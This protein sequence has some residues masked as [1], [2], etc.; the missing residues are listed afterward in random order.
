MVGTGAVATVRT[1][2]R[3]GPVAHATVN[4]GR[5]PSRSRPPPGDSGHGILPRAALPGGDVE[6]GRVI[7][8][9]AAAHVEA[10]RAVTTAA[11]QAQEGAIGLREAAHVRL[12]DEWD[13]LLR[14][15]GDALMEPGA[16]LTKAEQA[17]MKELSAAGKATDGSPEE[18]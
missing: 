8:A 3:H 13:Q 5:P 9:G 17:L 2:S 10:Y 18:T 1:V 12:T 15:V 4:G 6:F 16:D 14:D 11:R 7:A